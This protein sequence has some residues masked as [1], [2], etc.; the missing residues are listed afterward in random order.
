MGFFHSILK[1]AVNIFRKQTRLHSV[2][3][4]GLPYELWSF[5]ERDESAETW[6]P[7]TSE[8]D[9]TLHLPNRCSPPKP[10]SDSVEF[11]SESMTAAH[12]NV[13]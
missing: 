5:L 10:T 9:K 2:Y 4:G 7:G 6:V 13:T 12:I 1:V 11:E 8:V 3:T